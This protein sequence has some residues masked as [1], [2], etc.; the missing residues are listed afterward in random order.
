ML[1]IIYSTYYVKNEILTSTVSGGHGELK[2]GYSCSFLKL[3]SQ[4]KTLFSSF[5]LPGNG[6]P[7]K[8]KC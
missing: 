6:K 2:P 7:E 5:S 3:I 1:S 8:K 4:V